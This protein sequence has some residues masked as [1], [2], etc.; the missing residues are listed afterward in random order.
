[1][2]HK[3]P[4]RQRWQQTSL[5]NK[6]MIGASLLMAFGTLFYAAVAVFQY[7]MMREQSETTKAQLEAMRQQSNTIQGQLDTMKDQAS[8]MREQTDT[9]K[10]SLTETQKIVRQNEQAVKAAGI[11][12]GAAQTSANATVEGARIAGRALSIGNR[13]YVGATVTVANLG[14][15]KIPV[16]TIS[17]TNAGNTPARDLHAVATI[18][19]RKNSL[20]PNP[21]D[22][23]GSLRKSQAVLVRGATMALTFRNQERPLN[24]GAMAILEA[25]QEVIYVYGVVSYTDDISS[26]CHILRFCTFYNPKFARF[27]SCEYYNREEDRPKCPN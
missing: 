15:D 22:E 3:M 17:L 25:G 5:P 2:A 4:L 16:F 12:A 21:D 18:D 26:K 10:D 14:D 27:E 19:P 7:R 11:S 6:L 24:Q 9:L 13:P 20:P 8:T 23:S 1:M